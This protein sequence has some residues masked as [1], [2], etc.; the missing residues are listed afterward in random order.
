LSEPLSGK[1]LSLLKK[2]RLE[3]D[4]VDRDLLKSLARRNRSIERMA[5]LKYDKGLG[6][7]QKSRWAEVMRDRLA[8]AES[9]GVDTQLI[10]KIFKEIQRESIQRQNRLMQSFARDAKGKKK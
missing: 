1:E 3:I 4:K 2:L 6:V 10:E 7:R 9:L 5:R 8:R